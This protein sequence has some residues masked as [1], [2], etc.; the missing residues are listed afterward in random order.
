VDATARLVAFSS[1]HPIDDDDSGSDFDLMVQAV[2]TG[3]R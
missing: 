3:R 1:R 2:V